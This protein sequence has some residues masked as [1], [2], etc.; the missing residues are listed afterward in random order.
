MGNLGATVSATAFRPGLCISTNRST[1]LNEGREIRTPNLLIWSQTRCRC[2]IPPMTKIFDL[3]C[4]ADLR[5]AYV[6]ID[7]ITGVVEIKF[8]YSGVAQW[9]ACWAHNPKVRGSKPRSAISAFFLSPL[10]GAHCH[11]HRTMSTI[12]PYSTSKCQEN[13]PGRTR[14][15]NPRL[16]RPMPYPLGHGAN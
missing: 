15:C 7:C 11:H 14:T 6:I 1:R 16:R 10:I 5:I 2:A 13:D 4:A 8:N 12:H 9:L 3:R